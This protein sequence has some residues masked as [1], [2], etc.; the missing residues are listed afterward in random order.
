MVSKRWSTR[1]VRVLTENLADLYAFSS[2]V[3]ADLYAFSSYVNTDLNLIREDLIAV[4]L[5]LM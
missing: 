5:L 1:F 3:D 4:P 2:Y